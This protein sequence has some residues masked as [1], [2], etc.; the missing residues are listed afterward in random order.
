[1]RVSAW[2]PT[3]FL[4]SSEPGWKREAKLDAAL[5]PTP[6]SGT[7]RSVPSYYTRRHLGSKQ[8]LTLQP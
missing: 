1:M 4:M 6:D 8:G 2:E 7:Q 3:R 5:V